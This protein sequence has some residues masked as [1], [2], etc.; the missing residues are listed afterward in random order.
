MTY[1]YY[2][3]TPDGFSLLELEKNDM[4]RYYIPKKGTAL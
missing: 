2:Y 1:K 3:E 4:S